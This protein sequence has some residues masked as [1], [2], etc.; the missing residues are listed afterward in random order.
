MVILIRR[1]WIFAKPYKTRL[2]LGLLCGALFALTSGALMVMVRFV[3]AAVF[4]GPHEPTLATE[5]D[6]APSLLQPLAHFLQRLLLRVSAS[7]SR[8]A[9]VFVICTLPVLALLRAVSGYLNMYFTN[10]AAVRTIADLRRRLFEH[11]QSQPLSFF[12]SARTGDLIA[13][14]VNDTQALYGII[15]TGMAALLRDPLT[16]ITLLVVLLSQPTTRKLTLI[17]IIVLPACVVPVTI[18]ARKVRKSARAMQGHLADLSNLMHEAF[19][20]NRIIKAYNLELTVQKQFREITSR[21]VT[22]AMRI[23]RANELPSQATEFLGILGVC[24][25]LLFVIFQTDTARP[26]TSGEFIQFILTIVLM[27]QPIKVLV[28]LYNQMHQAASASHQVFAYLDT[29]STQVEAANPILL[30]AAGADIHFDSVD[31]SYGDK[32]VLREINLTIKA[33]QFVALVGKTGSGKTSITNLLLRFYDP[34]AGSVRIGKADLREV[35]RKDLRR[36]IALVAQDT[37]LFNDTI[38]QNIRL[39]REGATDAE[40]EEAARHAYAHD[41]ILEKP[42]GYETVVGEKGVTLSGGQR[43]RVAIA[44]A[45]LRDAPILILDE[46]TSALDSESERAVQAALEE[47]TIGRTTICIAHRLSTIQKADRIVVLEDGRIVETGTHAELIQARGMYCKLYELQ[48][49]VA[50]APA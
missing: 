46:A 42:Q 45:L 35:A 24:L 7:D 19:T 27:Y 12:S 21:F 11:L 17:S 49:V 36:Q 28:R 50:L 8:D 4:P 47:L 31:F 20:G 30:K 26:P 16:I 9:K 5:L 48:Y 38:R 44:R 3:A 34:T 2:I 23:V 1:L 32:N 14:T 22:H 10:W 25:V 37:I 41:F 15:S 43:Q 40:V 33:G 18:Y 6:K 29:P 39:G 13:R